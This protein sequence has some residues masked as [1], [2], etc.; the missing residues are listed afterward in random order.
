MK[1]SKK[2]KII[3]STVSL[4]SP[5]VDK[6]KKT[7][8]NT[9]Y[10]SISDFVTDVLRTVLVFKKIEGENKNKFANKDK[11]IVKERLRALGYIK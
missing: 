5:L 8:K 4:P 3:Y 9:G 10:V 6:I 7:I 2:T 11:E 1:I